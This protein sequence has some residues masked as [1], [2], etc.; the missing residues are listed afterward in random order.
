MREALSAES[1][2]WGPSLTFALRPTTP[3]PG[4]GG[5]CLSEGGQQIRLTL[6]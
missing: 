5:V 3:G 6:R 2:G 4:S 1:N